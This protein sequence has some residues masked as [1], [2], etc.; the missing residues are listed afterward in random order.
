[1]EAVAERRGSPV[2]L[3][4]HSLGGMLS[5]GLLA[6]RRPDLVAGL[7]TLAARCRPPG[8]TTLLTLGCGR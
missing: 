4:G 1:M 2:Q 7:V 6:G 3:V 8:R 5:R